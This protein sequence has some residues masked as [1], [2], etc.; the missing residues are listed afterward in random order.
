MTTVTR[1]TPAS[2]RK[3]TT[4]W[5][6]LQEHAGIGVIRNEREYKRMVALLD[7]VIDEGGAD[8]NHPLAGLADVLG[9]LVERYEESRVRVPQAEPREVLDYLMKENGLRQSD[10]A[11]ELG[12]Q[13]VVSEILAGK[14]AINARQAKALAVRFGVSPAAFI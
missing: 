8:E 13:G 11:D 14:R 9:E 12:S 5:I 4:A 7:K 2:F 1:L 10:L 6:Q 3:I